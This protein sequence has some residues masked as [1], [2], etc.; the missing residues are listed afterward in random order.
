MKIE[1]IFPFSKSYDG[2]KRSIENENGKVFPVIYEDVEANFLVKIKKNISNKRIEH[3]I[4]LDDASYTLMSFKNWEHEYLILIFEIEST[5]D[6]E[7]EEYDNIIENLCCEGTVISNDK[8][9]SREVD[10]ATL[11]EYC[12]SIFMLSLNFVHFEDYRFGRGYVLIEDKLWGRTNKTP[13]ISLNSED[14]E[15]K[16]NIQKINIEDVWNYIFYTNTIKEDHS[17]NNI[18]R[19]IIALTLLQAD[20]EMMPLNNRSFWL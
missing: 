1:V 11:A 4:Q 16:Y 17:T 14:G 19:A 9:S 18:S 20:G 5:T 8:F 7:P 13:H 3:L 2:K 10:Y 12:S 6:E 15:Q